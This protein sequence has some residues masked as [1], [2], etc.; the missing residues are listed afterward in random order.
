M[1]PAHAD[2]GVN[3]RMIEQHLEK[4]SRLNVFSLKLPPRLVRSLTNPIKV[5][6]QSPLSCDVK[7]QTNR[8]AMDYSC[9]AIKTIKDESL[10][11]AA[12]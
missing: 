10:S 1:E 8:Q 12:N 5:Q 4:M 7:M 6:P 9:D 3:I 2:D 11:I